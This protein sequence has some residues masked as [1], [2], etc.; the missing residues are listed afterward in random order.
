M[1]V[2]HVFRSRLVK[3]PRVCLTARAVG[4]YALELVVEMLGQPQRLSE[5][6]FSTLLSHNKGTNIGTDDEPDAKSDSRT[7]GDS[8]TS[9]NESA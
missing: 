3:L 5:D 6:Q 2:R 1:P 9:T 7:N 4:L 8:D